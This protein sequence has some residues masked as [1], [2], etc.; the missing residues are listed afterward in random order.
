MTRCVAPPNLVT[1]HASPEAISLEHPAI[2]MILSTKCHA[3]LHS[4]LT[5]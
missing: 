5:P 2:A 4:S 3:T 1:R